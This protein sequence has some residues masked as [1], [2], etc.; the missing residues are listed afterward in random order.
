[1]TVF[2]WT[3]EGYLTALTADQNEVV[4]AEPFA[5]IELQVALLFGDEN[6]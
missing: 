1:M 2:R 4:R 3:A 5:A 6:A